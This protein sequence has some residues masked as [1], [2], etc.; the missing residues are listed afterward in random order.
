MHDAGSKVRFELVEPLNRTRGSLGAERVGQ[1][2][3][4]KA[5]RILEAARHQHPSS[6]QAESGTFM[7]QI[8]ASEQVRL[9]LPQHGAIVPMKHN[10]H[11]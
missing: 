4:T 10:L 11:E 7:N 6:T 5:A 2:P 1:F 3:S 9:D 8:S